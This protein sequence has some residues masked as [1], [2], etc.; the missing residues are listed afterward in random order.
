MSNLVIQTANERTML[1]MNGL[2]LRGA[3]DML[4]FRYLCEILSVRTAVEALSI[5]GDFYHQAAITPKV[6]NKILNA[7][8]DLHS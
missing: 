1:A 5:I 7:L 2:A 4:D 6:H 3:E 8:T